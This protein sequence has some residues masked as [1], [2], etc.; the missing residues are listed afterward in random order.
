MKYEDFPILSTEQYH[1]LNTHYNKNETPNRNSIVSKI[2]LQIQDTISLF[3]DSNNYNFKIQTTISE[4]KQTLL[5]ILD[6]LS[7]LFNTQTTKTESISTANIFVFMTQLT[8]ILTDFNQWV[9]IEEKL[10]YKKTATK[11]SQEILFCLN[12][13]T[14]ACNESFISFYK[15]M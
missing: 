4:S 10:F 15:H 9:S 14:K 7:S 11:N 1:I 6:N 3:S 5:K 12:E 13:I 8:N 2:C